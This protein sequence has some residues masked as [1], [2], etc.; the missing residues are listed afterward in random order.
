MNPVNK[1]DPVN[2]IGI[3]HASL[4]AALPL[5]DAILGVILQYLDNSV[6]IIALLKYVQ[7]GHTLRLQISPSE[8]V[9]YS[10]YRVEKLRRMFSQSMFP[11]DVAQRR[12]YVCSL[13][14]PDRHSYNDSRDK[15]G[16]TLDCI[17]CKKFQVLYHGDF[18]TRDELCDL[19]IDYPFERTPTPRTPLTVHDLLTNLSGLEMA[20]LYKE[21]NRI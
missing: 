11:V 1:M 4:F 10:K 3:L 2:A 17:E 8:L 16:W 12:Y 7:M 9:N 18:I 20:C 6:D 5:C 13:D 14:S 21:V 19:G 15:E